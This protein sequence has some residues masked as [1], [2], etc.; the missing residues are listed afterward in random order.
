MVTGRAKAALK[1][2]VRS[3]FGN[4]GIYRVFALDLVPSLKDPRAELAE[5]GFTVSEVT[6]DDVAHAESA[7][8]RQTARYGGPGSKGFAILR[9]GGIVAVAWYWFGDHRKEEFVWPLHDGECE[10]AYIAT[11][12]EM[13]GQRLAQRVKQYAAREM[14]K[15]GFQRSYGKVWHNHHASIGANVKAGFREVAFYVDV[16]PL[17]GKR[18]RLFIRTRG[19]ARSGPVAGPA[20]RRT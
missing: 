17:G 3:L 20:Y 14:Q 4:V 12:P 9:S 2:I 8:V 13:R 15:L 10:S 19:V 5:E 18:R 16:Y 7:V 1:R 11:V 6:A